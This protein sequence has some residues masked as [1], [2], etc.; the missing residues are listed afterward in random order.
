LICLVHFTNHPDLRRLLLPPDWEGYPL[1][2]DFPLEFVENAWTEKHLPV[3]T[4]VEL[5]QLQQRRAYGLEIL[6]VPQER[7]MR[8]IFRGGKDVMPKGQ[9]TPK[10]IATHYDAK[11]F[12]TPR[13]RKVAGFVLTETAA[14]RNVWNKAMHQ[15]EIATTQ[16]TLLDSPEMVLNM[17]PQ[18]PSTHGVLRVVLKLDGETVIDLDCDI[19][20][21]HRG[22]EKIAENR[23]YT[24]IAPYWDRLD[25]IAAVSNG[26]VWVE[27]SSR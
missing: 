19:G 15:V 22:M 12:D 23:M 27:L 25:Y 3:M 11:V 17:G 24:M 1:R 6:S 20:Y 18:H 21:L 8:D 5:E 9:M 4:E 16:E 26:L 14:P 2:K 7:M 10:E 13:R